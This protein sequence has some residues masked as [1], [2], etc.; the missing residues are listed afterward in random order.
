MKTIISQTREIIETLNE[1]GRQKVRGRR[2][3][4]RDFKKRERNVWRC[5][6]Q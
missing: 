5:K 3:E 6:L 1:V 4:R 2:K